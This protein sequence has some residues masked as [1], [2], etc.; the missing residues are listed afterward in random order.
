MT[1]LQLLKKRLAELKK[2][3][4]QALKGMEP[5]TNRGRPKGSK[6]KP[7]TSPKKRGRPRKEKPAK[8]EWSAHPGVSFVQRKRGQNSDSHRWVAVLGNEVIGYYKTSQ[9]A[10]QAYNENKK[11]NKKEN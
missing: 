9:D 5:K 3:K 8:I 7:K 1:N 11:G 10:E 4:A 6:N 2:K